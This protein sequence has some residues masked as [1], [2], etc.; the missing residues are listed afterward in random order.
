VTRAAV[1]GTLLIAPVIRPPVKVHATGAAYIL[2]LD[3]V[4]VATPVSLMTTLSTGRL[5]RAGP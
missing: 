4:V 5:A 2:L 3:W 1:P